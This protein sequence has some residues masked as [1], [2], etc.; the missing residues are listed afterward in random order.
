[1]KK[2]AQSAICC[3]F[4]NEKILAL[5]LC[6]SLFGERYLFNAFLSIFVK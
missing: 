4:G 1:L 2:G 3:P 6:A 5:G